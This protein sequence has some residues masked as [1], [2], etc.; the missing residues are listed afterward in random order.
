MKRVTRAMVDA[1]L[2]K[3]MPTH[4]TYFNDRGPV[5]VYGFYRK[6]AGPA[7]SL[8]SAPGAPCDGVF[9]SWREL[10]AWLER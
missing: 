7:H 9:K 8:K 6:D 10:L 5:T 1:W 2:A 3:N 4:T